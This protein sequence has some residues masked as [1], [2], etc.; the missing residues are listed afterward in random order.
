MYR[1]IH[2]KRWVLLYVVAVSLI[3]YAGQANSET[4][5]DTKQE[6]VKVELTPADCTKLT[7]LAAKH[8]PNAD[9][10]YKEGIDIYGNSVDGANITEN[11]VS[12]TPPETVVVELNI[13]GLVAAPAGI[14]P[15]A[16][17]GTV[18]VDVKTGE[19]VIGGKPLS[20][21]QKQY[22]SDACKAQKQ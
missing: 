5:S 16:K 3:V 9:V 19:L 15:E 1:K 20:E 18:E 10:E 6:T 21:A 22:L 7:D 4:I 14:N 11:T 12:I 8:T 13:P 17:L 2:Y